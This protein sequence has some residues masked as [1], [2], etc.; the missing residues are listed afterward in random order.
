[1][2]LSI[3]ENITKWLLV[4]GMLAL[5]ANTFGQKKEIQEA[6]KFFEEY[7]FIE[8]IDKY[9]EAL[10]KPISEKTEIYILSQIGRCYQYSF[11]YTPAEYYFGKLVEMTKDKKPEFILEYAIMLKFNGKYQE[12]KEQ[13]KK[14]QKLTENQDPYGSFQMRS[15]NW[16]IANDTV[17]KP[18]YIGATNLD[19]TGQSLGYSLFSNGIIHAHT[20]NKTPY[21]SMNYFSLGYAKRLDSLRFMPSD[22]FFDSLDFSGNEGFPSYNSQTSTLYFAANASAAK[23]GATKKIGGTKHTVLNFKIYQATLVNGQF[24]KVKELPF[25]SSDFNC[26]HPFITEDESIIYFASDMPGGFGGYD[27]YLCKKGKDGSWGSPINMGKSINSEENEMYPFVH[28]EVFYY[29]SK[30]LN[31][32]GGYDIYAA[33]LNKTG[34]A[35]SP[36]NMGKPYNSFRDDFAFICYGDGTT[37][38]LSSNRGN[39]D[40]ED[41]VF[42]FKEFATYSKKQVIALNESQDS[43]KRAQAINRK[44]QEEEMAKKMDDLLKERAL[45]IEQLVNANIDPDTLD[46]REDEPVE[47]AETELST[48][49]LK[50]PTKEVAKQTNPKPEIEEDDEEELIKIVFNHVNFGFNETTLVPEVLHILDSAAATIRS[51]NQIRVEILAHTDSRGT[52]VYNKDLSLKRA[53]EARSYLLQKGVPSSKIVIRGFGEDQLLNHCKDGVECTEEEHSANRRVELKIVR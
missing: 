9:N 19:V 31:G 36:K 40:G 35:N 30:G 23:G 41:G 43:I 33:K 39:D 14:Y 49:E 12:A 52:S 6:N 45:L 27:L 32:Y 46:I 7:L 38:Y 29:S 3:K 22:E 5:Y 8:A 2:K 16:A 51:G 25:N 15:V 1:M 50:L 47:T 37:G 24:S 11:N 4:A 26:T 10:S 20:R 53:A 18:V 48:D 44:K 34:T 17:F 21:F 13:F 42:F 28:N